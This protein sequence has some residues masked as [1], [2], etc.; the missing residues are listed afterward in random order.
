MV[1]AA[2]SGHRQIGW[3]HSRRFIL[4]QSHGQVTAE[5]NGV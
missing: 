4:R 5:K 2:D 3:L 1:L